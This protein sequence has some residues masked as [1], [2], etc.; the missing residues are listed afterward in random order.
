MKKSVLLVMLL[1]TPSILLSAGYNEVSATKESGKIRPIIFVHG[2]SGSGDQFEAQALRF[3]SN[4]YPD[5]YIVALDHNSSS[6][7]DMGRQNNLNRLINHMLRET[8]ADKV[9]L[10]G[11]SMGTSISMFYLSWRSHAAKVAHYINIDGFGNIRL[12]GGVPTLNIMA[13]E[14][15]WKTKGAKNVQLEEHT[16]VQACSSPETFALMYEFITGQAPATTDILPAASDII[17]LEGK[18]VTFVTNKVPDFDLLSIYEVDPATGQRLQSSPVHSQHLALDGSFKFSNA[19]QG[20]AYEF[21]SSRTGEEGRGHWFYEPFVRTDRLIRLKYSKPGSL[22][23]NLLDSSDDSVNVIIVRN[24]E[25]LGDDAGGTG[26][27]SITVNGMEI[28]DNLLP[29]DGTI[30]VLVFD[31]DTDG[32]SN[33]SSV[34][35]LLSF[36]PFIN[37]IDMHIP[38]SQSGSDVVNVTIKDRYSSKTQTINIPN[39]PSSIHKSFVQFIPQ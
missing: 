29:E 9:E 26:A 36:V 28:C 19:K 15:A 2:M 25:M 23:Y 22:A 32:V 20:S 39:R 4:G 24:R 14:L 35:S 11:H 5:N 38:A 1:L 37:G 8:G 33:L 6:L 12:P 17:E 18:A 34:T 21:V 31:E 13:T 27:D 7:F 16:H 10:V 3:A 30:G